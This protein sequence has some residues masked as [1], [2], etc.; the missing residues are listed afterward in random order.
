V[1]ESLSGLIEAM[2]PKEKPAPKAQAQSA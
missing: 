1:A 2:Q